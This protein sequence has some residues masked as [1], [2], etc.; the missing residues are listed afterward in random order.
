MDDP[1]PITDEEWRKYAVRLAVAAQNKVMPDGPA[2][3]FEELNS[4]FDDQERDVLVEFVKIVRED[5]RER[6]CG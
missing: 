4:Q 1:F 5:M 2:L 6:Q 3:T